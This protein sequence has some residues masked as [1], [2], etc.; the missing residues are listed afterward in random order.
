MVIEHA[1]IVATTGQEDAFVADFGRAHAVIAAAAGCHWAQLT[2]TVEEPSTFVLLVGWDDVAAHQAFR[3]SPSFAD[4]RAI[5][6]PYFATAAV[7][8]HLQAV[9]G[10][11]D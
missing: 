8:T 11:R 2:R 4:W 7:V 3:D 9:G 1:V 5:V 10:S 6:G